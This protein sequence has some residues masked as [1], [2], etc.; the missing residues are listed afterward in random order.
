M[1]AIHAAIKW[2]AD[3]CLQGVRPRL[4][5]SRPTT[6]ATGALVPHRASERT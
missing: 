5:L 3:A 2:R 1:T 4:W 6:P